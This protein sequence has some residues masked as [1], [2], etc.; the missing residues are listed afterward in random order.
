MSNSFPGGSPRGAGIMPRRPSYASVVSGPAA[1]GISLASNQPTRSEAYS[2]LLNGVEFDYNSYYP[3]T[4]LSPNNSSGLGFYSS[5]TS[6][7]NMAGGYGTW[8]NNGA[9]LPSFSRAFGESEVGG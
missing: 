8:G 2:N 9:A 7:I 1:S 6:G 3:P 5:R 4:S